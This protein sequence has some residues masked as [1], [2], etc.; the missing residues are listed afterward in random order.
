MAGRHYGPAFAAPA[1]QAIITTE[2]LP[3]HLTFDDTDVAREGNA[4]QM[5]PIRYAADRE[6]LGRVERRAIQCI[7]TDHALTLKPRP[8]DSQC[9]QRHAAR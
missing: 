1:D 6:G 3:Q 5:I 2:T 4:L 9:T 7:A 8:P